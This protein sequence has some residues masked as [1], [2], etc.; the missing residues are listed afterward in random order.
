MRVF[1]RLFTLGI[2][3]RHPARVF[4][5]I[6]VVFV[7]AYLSAFT[8]VPREGGR[9]LNGDAIQY[10][11]YFRSMAIDHDLDFTND[12]RLLYAPATEEAART[13]VWLTSTTS[14]GRPPNQMS[15]G[16]AL[17]WAPFFGVIY[18]VLALLRPIGVIVPLDGIAAPF[19]LSAG[20]AG[21]VYAALG[22]WFCYRACRV[23]VPERPAF[24]G[25]MVAWLASPAL[26]YSLVS[27]AYSHAPSMFA[28]AAFCDVWLRT[29]D[30]DRSRRYV[31]LGLIAGL[32]A[33]VR[34]QDVVVLALPGFELMTAAARGRRSLVSLARPLAIVAAA[35]VLMLVPQFLAW[36]AIY[37]QAVVI[38]QGAGFMR[39]TSPALVPVL[40]SLRHGLLT[41]T[42][43]VVVALVGFWFVIRR[44]AL[45]GWSVLAVFGVTLYVNAS[46]SDWWAGEA[47]GARRFVSDTPLFALG[48]ACLF[49][50]NFWTRH[51]VVLRWVAVALV[52]SNALFLLQ[53]QL[54]MRGGLALAPYP[55]SVQQ[56]LL[57]RFT[58]PW[59][60][61]TYLM[62]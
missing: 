49:A 29:R 24:W 54:F 7:A 32:A 22:A 19:P 21:I 56:V 33:L 51:P 42:P 28:S 16:P 58:L 8:L 3:E 31:W 9:V 41:W 25:A 35:I 60:L 20:V 61:F 46:V 34:W 37:G 17:L 57:D 1:V 23:L 39:W 55:T 52:A 4:V 47:F 13:N 26:Y 11:A 27:P 15:I 62:R 10:Y 53:Y 38:P 30:D 12:Y 40:L 45:V 18:F 5:T 44:D 36:H 48:L 50:R 2:F 59:R 6:G 14:A 43:A